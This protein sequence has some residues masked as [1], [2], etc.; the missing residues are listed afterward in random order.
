MYED[1]VAR[2]GS[3]ATNRYTWALFES[4]FKKR[5]SKIRLWLARY[6]GRLVAGALCFYHNQHVAYWHSASS[7]ESYGKLDASHVL[8]Y[9]IINDACQ[10]GFELYDFLPSGGIEGV[11]HFKSGFSPQQRP[12]HIYVSPFMRLSSTVRDKLRRTL[13]YRSLMKGTGF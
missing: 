2:W 10:N 7:R 6:E 13:L 8:Q 5:S 1:T 3:A 11:A 12:I 9:F 4:M